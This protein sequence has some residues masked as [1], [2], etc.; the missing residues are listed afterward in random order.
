MNKRKPTLLRV[1]AALGVSL[2]I[3]LAANASTYYMVNGKIISQGKAEDA[4]RA[5]PKLKVIKLQVTE[6]ELND[7]TGNFKKSSD[8]SI[9]E[10]RAALK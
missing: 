1:L 8:L 6:V 5:N 7:Q 2:G 4:I 3:S 9:D 10:V